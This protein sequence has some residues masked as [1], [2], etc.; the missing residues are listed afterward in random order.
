MLRSVSDEDAAVMT[1]LLVQSW[2][3]CKCVSQLPT[4]EIALLAKRD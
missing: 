2:P 4:K 1:S 3:C